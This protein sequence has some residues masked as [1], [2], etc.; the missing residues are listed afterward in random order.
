[1]IHTHVKDKKSAPILY[2][3]PIGWFLLEQDITKAAKGGV[4]SKIE[5]FGNA[6]VLNIDA[7]ALT[8]ALE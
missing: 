6:A 2:K 7:E 1:M 5:C 4:I 8:A 3:I